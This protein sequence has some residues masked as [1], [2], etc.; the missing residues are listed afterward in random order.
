MAP[1][2]LKQQGVHFA[3]GKVGGRYSSTRVRKK[4]TKRLSQ[5]RQNPRLLTHQQHHGYNNYR[6]GGHPRNE[7]DDRKGMRH[8]CTIQF[9]A[10]HD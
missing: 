6:T 9:C 10:S 7:R 4:T 1:T 2:T 3:G 8:Y 5:S